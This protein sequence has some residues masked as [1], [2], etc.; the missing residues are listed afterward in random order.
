[1]LLLPTAVECTP[2]AKGEAGKHAPDPGPPPACGFLLPTAVECTPGAKGEP[3]KHAPDPEPPADCM[4]GT[5]SSEAEAAAD[6]EIT[7][8]P[9]AAGAACL[10]ASAC[11]FSEAASEQLPAT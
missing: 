1:M 7:A 9:P 3:G 11:S 4:K 5:S 8:P 2:G 6:T 10:A